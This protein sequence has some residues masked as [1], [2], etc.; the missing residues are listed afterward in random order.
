MA[1]QKFPPEAQPGS[2][3]RPADRGILPHTSAPNGF[4]FTRGR[5]SAGPVCGIEGMPE[6]LHAGWR[7]RQR[8][9]RVPDAPLGPDRRRLR[10]LAAAKAAELADRRAPA[11]PRIGGSMERTLKRGSG[12]LERYRWELGLDNMAREDLDPVEFGNFALSMKPDLSPSGWRE[13]RAA[14]L[15]II[16]RTPH[17]RREFAIGMLEA[18][19]RPDAD[20]A[21]SHLWRV[22]VNPQNAHQRIEKKHFD[23]ICDQM[24]SVSTSDALPWLADWMT[25][26]VSTGVMPK[27]GRASCRERV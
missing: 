14:A 25:A 3:A 2:A 6:D 10:D 19:T 22:G 12:L 16:E 7:Y 17:E 21:R 26:T 4:L 18:D 5:D 8:Y 15:T 11:E 1:D 24:G 9:G 23:L 13:C 27:I 20:E